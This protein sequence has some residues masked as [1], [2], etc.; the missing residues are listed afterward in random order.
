MAS[1]VLDGNYDSYW[2]AAAGQARAS[3]ELDF[4]QPQSFNRILIQEFVNLGQRV[5][6]FTVEKQ[7]EGKW[8]PLA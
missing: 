2:A 4:G 6:A 7:V 8:L 5:S 3:V 1:Q